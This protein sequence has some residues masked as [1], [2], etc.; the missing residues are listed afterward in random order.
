MFIGEVA[1]A[2]KILHN[3]YLIRF[4]GIYW[5]CLGYQSKFSAL[6]DIRPSNT[7]FLC[8]FEPLFFFIFLEVSKTY[9]M[10]MDMKVR[11]SKYMKKLRKKLH[12]PVSNT[13]WYWHSP[14]CQSKDI[15][16][17]KYSIYEN[18]KIEE[19]TSWIKLQF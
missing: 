16:E 6:A 15:E 14:S 2:L 3:I 4:Y 11:L 1:F 10:Y 7:K 17:L 5:F 9:S 13:F 18:L 19:V 12:I 8:C